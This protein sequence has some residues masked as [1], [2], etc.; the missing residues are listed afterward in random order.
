MTRIFPTNSNALASA[1]LVATLA[2]A[3][4]P[5]WL[6]STALAQN[7]TPTSTLGPNGEAPAPDKH[8]TPPL[9]FPPSSACAFHGKPDCEAK[10]HADAVQ[11]AKYGSTGVIGGARAKNASTSLQG[12]GVDSGAGGGPAS[13]GGISPGSAPLGPSSPSST[14]TTASGANSIGNPSAGTPNPSGTGSG[15]GGT[16]GL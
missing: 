12:G 13:M 9:T 7:T 3:Q 6:P 8:P 5:L 2:L 16:G 1:A 14:G 11:D 15:V 10:V 4:V